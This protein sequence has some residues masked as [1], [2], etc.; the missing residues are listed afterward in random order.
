MKQRRLI[1]T[2]LLVAV[3][4]FS[5]C[6]LGSCGLLGGDEGG[7]DNNPPV[8]NSTLYSI[9]YVSG[10]DDATGTAPEAS[11]H[12]AGNEITL[13]DNPF[14]REGYTFKGWNDGSRVYTP[15]SKFSIPA[16]NVVFTAVW[17]STEKAPATT[18]LKEGFYDAS[19][20]VYM[21]NND[22]ET[23][24]GGDIPYSMNDGSI[25][26]HKSN[27]AYEFGDLSNATVSFM[28]KGTNDWSIWFNSSTKDNHNNSSYRL[29]YANGGIRI[30][31]SSAPDLAAA[32]VTG[33]LYN[34]GE[35]NRFDIVFST[36]D[37]VCQIKLYINGIRAILEAGDNTTPAVNVDDNILT[38]TQPAMFK[39]GNYVVVK[40]W[41]AHNYVQIKPVAKADEEDLPIIACIGASITEGAG[42]SN[43]YT[44]SYPAQLQN[45]LAGAYNVINFGNSGKTVRTD[46]GDDVAWLKQYQW[47]GVQA[48]VP[49][50]AILN[51][52][53][54]DSKTSNN[55]LSTYD[56]FYSAYMNLV[57]KLLEV[58]PDMEIIICT[59]PYAYSDI[60]GISNDNIANIIAPVQRAIAEEKDYTLIDLYKFTQNKA[61][62]FS[63]GV[64]PTTEGYEM[65][66]KIVKKAL[67]E[68]EEALTDEF[69][70]DL[71]TQYGVKVSNVSASIAASGNAINL[72]VSGDTTL[73]AGDYLKLA[74]T[75]GN[76]PHASV[77][78]VI[79]DG[80]FTAVIDLASLERASEWLNIR[81]CTSENVN[82][83]ILLSQSNCTAEQ[84]FVTGDSKV[85]IKTWS[86]ADTGNQGTLSFVLGDNTSARIDSVVIKGVDGAPTLI[87]SGVTDDSAPKFYIGIDP[88]KDVYN[89][90]VALAPDADGKFTVSYDLTKLT[91]SGGWYNVRI[92][93]NDNRY[94]VVSLDN[95]KDGEGNAITNNTV[96]PCGKTKVTI[97]TWSDGGVATLSFSVVN[98][99]YFLKGGQ[100][101]TSNMP[102]TLKEVDGKV[103]YEFVGEFNGDTSV[104]RTIELML[105][106]EDFK[107]VSSPDLSKLVY[108]AQN[109]YSG[110]SNTEFLF[111]INATD[112]LGVYG[113][114]W[115]RFILK[116]TEGDN[117]NYYLIKPLVNA[118]EDNWTACA[119]SIILDGKKYEMAINWSSFFILV[120]NA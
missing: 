53:T 80:K 107:G 102:F 54:N 7:G 1:I 114:S 19:E 100:V 83:L 32:V 103:Y 26:F 66:V 17:E 49:D 5:T 91:A 10:A 98:N 75:A 2:C 63:D 47:Q 16:R 92:Y 62:L 52:G 105:T 117:V 34:K 23:L 88:D 86:S 112:D 36:T 82:Q 99:E 15:G 120:K 58:N 9:A 101:S 78:A 115:I 94:Y 93:M 108:T 71:G 104:Q 81:L 96:I 11:S 35:W 45:A 119:P 95:L 74:I 72:T 48:I 76:K 113:D 111:K 20:W 3:L 85:V 57:N 14:S 18:E 118:H 13:I 56:N 68:G 8:N 73:K 6:L 42:A 29:A 59:V 110:T 25:K 87:V 89:D 64:H 60:W 40:V 46:L 21:T 41:E 70:A 12:V 44:E 30:A 33:D 61:H 84:E 97:C 67:I 38:H 39:T 27:Q 4:A 31:I 79:A 90:Y 50:I 55:P 37:G 28:L 51:I 77:D 65:I 109:V 69:I 43:F 22:G 24:D 106:L 116:V